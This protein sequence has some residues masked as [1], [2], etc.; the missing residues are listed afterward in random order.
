VIDPRAAVIDRRLVGVGRILLFAGGKGGVGKSACAAVGALMLARRGLRVGLLD[1][2]FEGASCHTFLGCEPRLPREDRGLLPLEEA[3]GV[4][5]ASVVSFTGDR[6]VAMRGAD[7]SSALLEILAV[8]VWGGLDALLIDMP[9]GMGDQLLDV[10]RH[11]SR[12][13]ALAVTT[14]SP[15]ALSVTSRLLALLRTSSVRTLGVVENMSRRPSPAVADLA[16]AASAGCLGFLPHDAALERAIGRPELLAATRFA[17]ALERLLAG[18]LLDGP[19]AG[20]LSDPT[21]RSAST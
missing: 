20:P 1:L 15:V 5:L 17:A 9:P 3:F 4:R 7:L 21:A 14:A 19:P 16:R 11:V 13:E 12:G 2:D 6:P 18:L 8:T 10:M